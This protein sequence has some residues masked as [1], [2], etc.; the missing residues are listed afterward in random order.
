MRGGVA[1]RRSSS[2]ADNGPAGAGTPQ[3]GSSQAAQVDLSGFAELKA[4]LRI[5][6]VR[7]LWAGLGLASLVDWLGLLSPSTMS[8][9]DPERS[10]RQW[11]W[12]R[13]GRGRGP[14]FAPAGGGAVRVSSAPV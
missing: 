14:R 12:V 9:A 4:I 13:H 10:A 1:I 2:G 6:P 7:R 3:A 8:A 5:R 11:V